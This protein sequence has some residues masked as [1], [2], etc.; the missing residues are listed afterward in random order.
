MYV[1]GVAETHLTGTQVINI[2]GFQWFGQNRIEI[3]RRAPAGSGGIGF[4]N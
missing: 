3:N 1:L 2:P 4:F